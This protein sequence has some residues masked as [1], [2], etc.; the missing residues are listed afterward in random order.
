M[1]N[2]YAYI[3][4]RASEAIGLKDFNSESMDGDDFRKVFL[5]LQDAI[6]S[7]NSDPI[8]LFGVATETV[9]VSGS[10]L[11]FKPYTD[12]EQAVIDGGG[13]V[14]ITDRIVSIRPTVPPYAFISGS[15]LD[16]VDPMD[17]PSY[18]DKCVCAWN[19]DYDQDFLQFGAPV[20]GPVT[21]QIRKPVPVPSVPSETVKIPERYHE[22][23]I[24]HIA[25]AMATKLGLAESLA[26]LKQ[27]L[28]AELVRVAGNVGYS[29]PVVMHPCMDRFC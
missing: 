28:A 2:T 22:Y 23:L 3:V 8:L 24:L 21:L 15:R 10:S 29:R 20:G 27:S 6:R 11:L 13:S 18:P 14:D 12:A 19:P 9:N 5:C 7:I 4:N 26:A 16:M 1:P 25:V 17:L